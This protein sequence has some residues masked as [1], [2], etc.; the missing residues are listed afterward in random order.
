MSIAVSHRG[1][2]PRPQRGFI[3][4]MF[5]SAGAA[6]AWAKPLAFGGAISSR[7]VTLPLQSSAEAPRDAGAGADHGDA[8]DREAGAGVHAVP[9]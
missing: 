6:S 7:A 1:E 5:G 8:G 4:M 9:G 3:S 2:E